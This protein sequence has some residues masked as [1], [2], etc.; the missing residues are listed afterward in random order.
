MLLAVQGA[1]HV[2]GFVIGLCVG[3]ALLWLLRQRY[4]AR[5]RLMLSKIQNTDAASPELP[6]EFQLSS[7][8]LSQRA[9]TETLHQQIDDFRL[10]MKFAPLGYLQ[11]NGENQLLWCNLQA[12]KILDIDSQIDQQYPRLLLALAR[13]YEL[14][15]LVERTRQTQTVCQLAWTFYSI[16]PDPY[17][18]SERPAYPIRG[19]GIPLPEGQV[20][21]FLEPRQDAIA[22]AQQRD[23]WLSDVA[24]EL[25]TPLTSIRLVA[26]TLQGRV[27]DSLKH[28]VER[29]IKEVVRL[30][31]LVDDVL[32]LSQLEQQGQLDDDDS[33]A[34][35]VPLIQN[36]CQSLEPLALLKQVEFV[37]SGPP[38]LIAQVNP[39]LMHRVFFNLL[40]N[41]VKYSPAQQTIRVQLRLDLTCYAPENDAGNASASDRLKA[42]TEDGERAALPAILFEVIDQGGGFLEQDLPHVFERFYRSDPA[43]SRADSEKS[44]Q[45]LGTAGGTGL[46]LAIVRRI[47]SAHQGWVEAQNHPDTGGGW[48][49]VWIPGNRLKSIAP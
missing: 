18:V 14:D 19:C 30:G 4:N 31:Q 25:K 2:I 28:W 1:A 49:K 27:D 20:G 3:L 32:S 43:R 29:L 45:E 15:Q 5:L 6:Y 34:D 10:V 39:G 11:V 26:E 40:N 12:Q 9:K 46:G 36:A 24:H 16:S 17:N 7:A 33:D 13:S 38:Q 41:A 44:A 37:Y 21:I 42:R 8:I 22:Q 48:L 23:R 35:L 47:V